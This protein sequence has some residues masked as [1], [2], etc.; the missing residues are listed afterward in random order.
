MYYTH[1][2]SNSET[3]S[4]VFLASKPAS[5]IPY[6][7]GI[8]VLLHNPFI[9]NLPNDI[10]LLSILV[11]MLLIH[12]VKNTDND[13]TNIRASTLSDIIIEISKIKIC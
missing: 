1:D 13:K 6:S 5:S 3:I 8:N 7:G 9:L 2:Y 10:P 11:A 4:I 12:C